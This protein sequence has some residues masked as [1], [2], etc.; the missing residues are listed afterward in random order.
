[1]AINQVNIPQ[2]N[3]GLATFSK[4]AQVAGPLVGIANPAAGA[5]LT[6]G[7]MAGSMYSN[8]PPPQTQ[9]LDTYGA[10]RRRQQQSNPEQGITDA[11]AALDT[12]NLPDDQYRKY[13]APLY[14]ALQSQGSV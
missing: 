3:S 9:S 10:M 14:Q 6:A 1:M 8:N 11:L 4:L 12:M 7:G 5:V 13:R 2:S